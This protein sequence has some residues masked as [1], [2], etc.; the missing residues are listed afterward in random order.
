MYTIAKSFDFSASHT[1]DG[2]APEHPCRRL[3]G[4]NWTV[5]LYLAASDVD[6]RGFVVDFLDLAPFKRYLDETLD[7]RHLNDVLPSSPTSENLSRHLYELARERW[8]AVVAC[9]VSE[10]PRTT[11]VYAPGAAIL[12]SR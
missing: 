8:P 2:V 5:T 10:T 9:A 12:L 1:L 11:A 7:H 6:A 4:H 3:H